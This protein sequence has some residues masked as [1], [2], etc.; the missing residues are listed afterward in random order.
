LGTVFCNGKLT[1]T[2]EIYIEALHAYNRE[3]DATN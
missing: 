1:G 2:K 3:L